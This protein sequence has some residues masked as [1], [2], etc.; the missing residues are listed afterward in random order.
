MSADIKVPELGESIV[1]ATITQWLKKTGETV[2]MDEIIAELE[3][4]KV[5]VEVTSPKSGVL[6]EQLFKEGDTVQ[7]GIIIGLIVDGVTAIN[8]Q[9]IENNDNKIVEDIKNKEEKEDIN[10]SPSANKLIIENNL[11]LDSIVGSGKRGQILKED[12]LSALKKEDDSSSNDLNT[13]PDSNLEKIVPLTKLR[14]TIANRLKTVQN[15]AA[16]LTTFNEV[17]MSSIISIREQHGD[18]FQSKHGV[19]LGYMGFFVRACVEALREYPTVNAQ[20][21]DNNIIYK[22]Y[23]NISIA[24]GTDKGL[25]VPVIKNAQ[26][27]EISDIEKEIN[28]LSKS[29]RNNN[30]SINSMQGGTFTITNGGIYGSLMSTPIL[31]APQS[32]ILGMH[33]IEKRPVVIND[34]IEIRPMMY[35]A[36]S[37]DHRIIDGSEAVSFLE[38]V[39]RSISDPIGNILNLF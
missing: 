22:N 5:S 38:H 27:L 30:L 36:L 3:T 29:A 37:Y 20:I 26:N 11:N 25:V 10:P 13:I 4:D 35:L 28:N 2:L 32:G 31:N 17:D 8:N 6:K 9:D 34:K 21:K 7:P 39:K 12:V 24:V 18:S 16:I 19:K 33:K 14:Q 23:Y 1:E 15:T